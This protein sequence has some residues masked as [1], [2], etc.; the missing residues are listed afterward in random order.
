M[1]NEKVVSILS[2]REYDY[3]LLNPINVAK[4]AINK[5]EN[6]NLVTSIHTYVL[7]I[8]NSQLFAISTENT[9]EMDKLLDEKRRTYSR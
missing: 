7:S 8:R 6:R 9:I 3:I 5:T 2:S 1:S 4:I